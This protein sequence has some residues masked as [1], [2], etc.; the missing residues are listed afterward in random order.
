MKSLQHFIT[1]KKKS[2]DKKRKEFF[3]KN[4]KLSDSDP[5][6]YKEAPGDEE[7]REK[8]LP[9]SQHTK[10]YERLYGD[11]DETNEAEERESDKNNA[12]QM[13]EGPLRSEKMEKALKKKSEET[14]VDVRILRVVARRGLAAWNSS[15]RKGA[16]QAQ[17][18]LARVNSFLTKGEGTWGKADADMAREVVKR[19]EDKKLKKG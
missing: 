10:D 13:A 4:D 16:G 7:A 2:I 6:A 8:G 18:A 17:W 3:K 15:H 9:K 19:G 14:G 12:E 5:D 11:D 1:E